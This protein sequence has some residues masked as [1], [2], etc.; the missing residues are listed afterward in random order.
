MGKNKRRQLECYDTFHEKQLSCDSAEE[1][2]FV[3]WCCEA[4][5]LGIIKDFSY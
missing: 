2:D 5:K 1:V 3:A 4:A